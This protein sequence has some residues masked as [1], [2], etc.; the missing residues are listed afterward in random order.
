VTQPNNLTTTRNV[1]TEAARGTQ[2]SAGW[3]DMRKDGSGLVA[4]SRLPTQQ[5]KAVREEWRNAYELRK[6]YC[7]VPTQ[8]QEMEEDE[9]SAENGSDS[10]YQGSTDSMKVRFITVFYTLYNS[11]LYAL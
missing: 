4:R 7:Q 6:K 3:Q 8:Q 2:Q 11:I 9:P 5:E 1:G 10:S